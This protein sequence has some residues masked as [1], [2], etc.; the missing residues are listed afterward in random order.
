MQ[1][2]LATYVHREMFFI[3]IENEAPFNIS[4]ICQIGE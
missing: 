2:R 4:K 3:E 1:L